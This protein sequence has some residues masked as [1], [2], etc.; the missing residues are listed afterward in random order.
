MYN[1][2]H[3]TTVISTWQLAHTFSQLQQATN[4]K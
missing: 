4:S 3:N 2:E 1:K